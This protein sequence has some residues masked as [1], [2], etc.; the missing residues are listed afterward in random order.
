MSK[1]EHKAYQARVREF[2]DK[3]ERGRR[4]GQMQ[5][6]AS[7]LVDWWKHSDP[8]S[9]DHKVP[10]G[11]FQPERSKRR[12]EPAINVGAG[13]SDP[14]EFGYEDQGDDGDYD[15][16]DP[17]QLATDQNGLQDATDQAP[18]LTVSNP[19]IRSCGGGTGPI[20]SMFDQMTDGKLS[21]LQAL[22]SISRSLY[23]YAVHPQWR[24][25]TYGIKS[26]IKHIDGA[27]EFLGDHV[28]IGSATR[29]LKRAMASDVGE[30]DGVNLESLIKRIRAPH[31][32]LYS[33][34][35]GHDVH[36]EAHTVCQHSVSV[37]GQTSVCGER[38]VIAS[39]HF[40]LEQWMKHFMRDPTFAKHI[41][42]GPRELARQ[43]DDPDVLSLWKGEAMLQLAEQV[44]LTLDNHIPVV[45]QMFIDGFE[46]T[47]STRS[48]WA[49]V[50]RVLNLPAEI[51][52]DYLFPVC[53]VDGKSIDGSTKPESIDASLGVSVEEL[54]SFYSKR[55]GPGKYLQPAGSITAHDVSTQEQTRLRVFLHSVICDMK[56][57]QYVAKHAMVP[58]TWVCHRC[59]VEG[60]VFKTPGASAQGR[61]STV[62]TT[63]DNETGGFEWTLK[64][65]EEARCECLKAD[66]Y[67]SLDT[68]SHLLKGYLGTPV[69]AALPYFDIVNS[70]LI[71]GM[72]QIHNV[73]LRCLSKSLGLSGWTGDIIHKFINSEDVQGWGG[74]GKD[75]MR[76]SHLPWEGH[77]G[78]IEGEWTEDEL[79]RLK[80][81]QLRELLVR[82]QL[83]KKGNK[84]DLVSRLMEH[85]ASQ[86]TDA[87]HGADDDL[88]EYIAAQ[89]KYD[90]SDSDSEDDDEAGDDVGEA[91][92]GC[93]DVGE[94]VADDQSDADLVNEDG[95]D[96]LLPRQDDGIVRSVFSKSWWNGF[97]SMLPWPHKA[98]VQRPG[99]RSLRVAH[100]F[101]KSV[102]TL[103]INHHRAPFTHLL[104]QCI[105]QCRSCRAPRCTGTSLTSS[106]PRRQRKQE[107]SRGSGR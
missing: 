45:T 74:T 63:I 47:E 50:V 102:R 33:C 42:D 25:V 31:R 77:P 51:A 46:P 62:Y 97:G 18:L 64:N 21:P 38:R 26:A 15:Y 5:S 32:T 59:D 86:P 12:R 95:L 16:G 78:P 29:F 100:A 3:S 93:D 20:D 69:F 89:Q 17:C 65:D 24:H 84:A 67:A 30:T 99:E 27:V 10:F 76:N 60:A 71:C 82:S 105:Y 4:R 92:D 44:D 22:K 1:D 53:L 101:A 81:P 58:G 48:V 6:V 8:E 103:P 107:A 87:S 91:G 28:S 35:H 49:V 55:P 40:S 98:R 19:P 52:N 11:L 68:H 37:C 106:I 13:S 56:A 7:E 75:W 83:D 73:V 43:Q 14:R 85:Q 66:V 39:Y 72:H 34:K 80:M 104:T 88:A 61:H 94:D 9:S 36:E 79:K 41:Q 70:F 57:M 96:A 54:Q 90:L 2:R 23:D